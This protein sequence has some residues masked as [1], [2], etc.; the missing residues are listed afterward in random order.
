MA[1]AADPRGIP[2]EER[3]VRVED[4]LNDKLQTYDDLENLE[5]LLFNVKN[6]HDLLTKQLQDAEISLEKAHKASESHASSLLRQAE[7]FQTRQADIGRRLLVVTRS[8][9]SGEATR[10]FES[11][12]E[13]LR[14]LDVAKGYVERLKEVEE[15]SAEARLRVKTSPRTAL[16]SYARLQ[17]LTRELQSLQPAAEG[18]A[19]HLVGHVEIASMSLR[20]Q[21][22]EVLENEFEALLNKIKWPSKE[23]RIDGADQNE[24]N[25][26]VGKLLELQKVDLEASDD[27]KGND[28]DWKEPSVL[29]PL[30]VMVKPLELRFRYH[31][32]GSKPTNRTDKPEYFLSHTISLLNTYCD[33]L[34]QY[35]GPVLR[36]QFAGSSV[37]LNPIYAD[38]T[39]AFITSLLPMLRRKISHLLPEI[40]GQPQLLSH[41][42]HELISFDSTLKEEWSYEGGKGL[43]N[44]KGL[45]WEVLVK[46]DWF[47]RWLQVEKE[48]ALSRYQTIVSTKD[49]WEIDYDVDP[50]VTKATKSAI[51][52]KDLFEAITD[53]YRPLS[54]LS[55][56]LRFLIDI[57]IAILDKF[58]NRLHSAIEAYTVLTSSIARAVQ[59][60][61]KEDQASLAGV[62]GLERL[63]R[64]YGSA[65]YLEKAM[66]DWSDDIFF[67]ELWEELQERA[68]RNTGKNLAGPMSVQEVANRT[69]SSVGSGDDTGGL[70]D[71]SAGAFNE[72]RV[73]TEG[74]LV[75]L[76]SS[77]MKETLRPYSRISTWSSLNS[78]VSASTS[79][80]T[81]ELD[82][83]VR[84]LS[85][86]LSFLSSALAPAPLRR[87]FRHLTSYLQQYLWDYVLMRNTFSTSGAVQF[88]R[89]VATMW[90]LLDVWLGEGQGEA[91]MRRLRE[92][93]GLLC[94][95]LREGGREGG[96]N[97]RDVERKVFE[98]NEKAKEVLE[99]MGVE[100]LTES[101]ARAVLERRVEL[102]S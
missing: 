14:G 35:L 65:E 48:F 81:L 93:V 100:V 102:G 11:S 8:E 53:R 27:G 77:N 56:K 85:T 57:Q 46:Q 99:E 26:G 5:S 76:L 92:G 80:I 25:E 95:P 17:N 73:R 82:P 10:R 13:K 40:V 91:G 89:D 43:E 18:A 55:Q 60:V 31:F 42:I 66:R 67:L 79:T 64:V 70:F 49:A 88:S 47:P 32:D 71:E 6:Q 98:S 2:K 101:E 97:L 12:M 68:R 39:S 7:A 23:V 61:S 83:P 22:K 58:H 9:T 94:L 63:C 45:A 21:M 78:D 4:Y 29:L 41:F 59:G 1:T 38:S 69:S 52:L 30:E 74:L 96:W 44:W 33:F 34:S 50:S 87:I 3:D 86:Y 24:W 62:G 54:S 37:G 16:K 75:E 19:P 84:Q 51:R 15:L 36:S 72:L 20:K 28:G 90:D